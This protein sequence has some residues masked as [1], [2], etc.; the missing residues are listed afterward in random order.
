MTLITPPK[1]FKLLIYIKQ[2]ARRAT[3]MQAISSPM[4]WLL[5]SLRS[6]RDQP[7][8]FD[9][10]ALERRNLFV[11]DEVEYINRSNSSCQEDSDE[12]DF[13]DDCN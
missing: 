3:K 13:N 2:N 11:D 9:S 5:K 1:S 6:R 12:D 4:H 7:K 8:G 10:K